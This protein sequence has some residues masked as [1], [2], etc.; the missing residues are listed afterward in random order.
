MWKRRRRR[1]SARTMKTG[2]KRM[3]SVRMS[4]SLFCANPQCGLEVALDILGDP[5]LVACANC[6][7]KLFIPARLLP[8]DAALTKAD[9][10]FLKVNKI[11]PT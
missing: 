6:G 1:I 7:G 2:R 5:E 11:S 4:R 3:A 10:T 8:W 9:L